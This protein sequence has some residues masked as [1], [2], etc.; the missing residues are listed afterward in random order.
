[1]IPEAFEYFVPSSLR[2]AMSLAQRYGGDAKFLSGGHSLLPL[3]KMRLAAPKYLIDLAGIPDM[4]QVSQTGEKLRIGARATH[5]QI[6]INPLVRKGCPLLAQTAAEIGDPQ[7]RNR[8]TLGGSIA[9]SD[10]AADYP[11][12]LLALDA[13]IEIHNSAGTRIVPA[14]D[15]FVDLFTSVLAEGELVV[16]VHVPLLRIGAGTAYKKLPQQASGFAV[17]GVATVL[18]RDAKGTCTR[19]A[20]AVTGVGPRPFRA[21]A[22]ETALVGKNL[23]E[24]TISDACRQIAASIDALSDIHASAEYR[25]A[26]T[27]VFAKR[28]IADAAARA[29][30]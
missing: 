29:Q 1:M 26:M 14:A 23:N 6:E 28:A 17:T 16:A 2:E 5:H 8:G 11:A 19:I 27:D 24:R 12:A 10:P 7:V 18:E 22:V 20:V 30:A 21:T 4:D 25:K 13:E 15:F 9:H 3:M